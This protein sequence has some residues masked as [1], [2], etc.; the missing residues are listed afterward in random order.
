MYIISMQKP[1][2]IKARVRLSNDYYTTHELLKNLGL[3]TVCEEAACPNIG[4]CWSRKYA[5]VMILGKNCTRSCRFCNI[6][7][8]NVEPVNVNEPYNISRIVKILGLK[9]VVITSV[10]R[11]DL[12]DGGASQFLRTIAM[13]RKHCPNTTIEV[14]TPDFL[15]KNEE[16]KLIAE[17]GIEVYNHNLETVPRLYKYVRPQANY[18]HSLKLLYEV[19][20]VNNDIFTKSGIM[21]GLGETDAEV[22]QVMEDLRAAKVDFLTIGQY[23]QPSPKHY[24]MIYIAEEKFEKYYKIAKRKGF[25]MIS[26][27]PMTRSSYHAEEDFE[28]LKN[29]N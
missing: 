10:D 26:S 29:K 14:L 21:V 25:S 23:L 16:Y 27:S 4:D 13:I 19:K 7:T 28:K 8:G 22:I 24:P 20:K 11:D 5:T 1:S 9:H 2:Y 17:S 15:N 6:A 12:P 18:F 3:N